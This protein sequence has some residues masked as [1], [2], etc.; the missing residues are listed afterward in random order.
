MFGHFGA[1]GHQ[2]LNVCRQQINVPEYTDPHAV[3]VQE[4]S[5][6]KYMIPLTKIPFT[7]INYLNVSNSTVLP[8]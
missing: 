2:L 8:I 6:S 3:L 4:I 5:A 7:I 1:L